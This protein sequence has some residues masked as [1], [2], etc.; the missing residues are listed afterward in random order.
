MSEPTQK[1]YSRTVRRSD[2]FTATKEAAKAAAEQAAP[3]QEAAL[4]ERSKEDWRSL[5]ERVAQHRLY[6]RHEHVPALKAAFPANRYMWSVDKFFPYAQGGV[7]AVDEPQIKQD[8]E[9]SRTK[10]A[11]LKS[12]GIRMVVLT[13]G[14]SYQDALD[15]LQKMEIG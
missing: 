12:M 7:L 10:Q 8:I 14:T 4:P 3:M 2:P 1:P 13:H 5:A 6:K 15:Q 11:F 9:E